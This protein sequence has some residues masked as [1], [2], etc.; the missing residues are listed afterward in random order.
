MWNSP[1]Q[2]IPRCDIDKEHMK[3]LEEA[4]FECEQDYDVRSSKVYEALDYFQA[5]TIRTWGFTL[6]RQGLE[7]W[8][9]HALHDGLRLIKQHIGKE[10]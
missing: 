2:P 7:D 3:A 1:N 6:F 4:V 8:N 10:N 9:P 5:K